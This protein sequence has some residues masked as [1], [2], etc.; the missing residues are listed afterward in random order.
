MKPRYV[1]ASLPPRPRSRARLGQDSP[2]LSCSPQEKTHFENV[3]DGFELTAAIDPA[4]YEGVV[5]FVL[6]R[7]RDGYGRRP[8]AFSHWTCSA[9]PEEAV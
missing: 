2:P 1:L 7:K 3:M 4:G 9:G 5:L 6:Q 8:V